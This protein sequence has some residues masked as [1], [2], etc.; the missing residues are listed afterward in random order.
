MLAIGIHSKALQTQCL[1]LEH[2]V[3]CVEVK[4]QCGIQ[5][6]TMPFL[7]SKKQFI[8]AIDGAW[9]R[10]GLAQQGAPVQDMSC[11][12]RT[13]TVAAQA[14]DTRHGHARKLFAAICQALQKHGV[15]VI[16]EKHILVHPYQPC[17]FTRGIHRAVECLGCTSG[18]EESLNRPSSLGDTRRRKKM[19]A[20]NL[21]I[22]DA[23]HERQWGARRMS[24][25]HRK[26]VSPPMSHQR[27]PAVVASSSV[28]V[29]TI[30]RRT[31]SV[32]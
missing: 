22:A 30:P 16:W 12:A 13:L 3:R 6:Q 25:V 18:I 5:L 8:Q 28:D 24:V 2:N 32:W 11:A 4:T 10:S 21:D 23:G 26:S 20:E 31:V 29:F 17:P 1:G 14:I 7:D 9:Q 15:P 19:S 27:S